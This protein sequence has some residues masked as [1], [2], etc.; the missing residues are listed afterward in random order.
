MYSTSVLFKKLSSDLHLC[1]LWLFRPQEALNAE[2]DSFGVLQRRQS[3]NRATW[4]YVRGIY[5]R[6]LSGFMKL[7]WTFFSSPHLLCQSLWSH[8][9]AP[10]LPPEI[11]LSRSGKEAFLCRP[12]VLT[13]SLIAA[14][15][16]TSLIEKPEDFFN[17]WRKAKM[18]YDYIKTLTF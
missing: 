12:V 1:F 17:S 3:E 15:F 9:S 14:G 18:L 11:D 7:W 4:L 8:H 13:Y 10:P 2:M 5:V 6:F 16:C